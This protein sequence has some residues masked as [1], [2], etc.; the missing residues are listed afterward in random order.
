MF[1]RGA[2]A[3]AEQ[4]Q[5]DKEEAQTIINRFYK[6]F[7]TIKKWMEKEFKFT[8]TH[9]YVET[10]WGRRRYIPDA[11]M[12]KYSF[13]TNGIL[14]PKDFNPLD[15]E[16]ESNEEEWTTEIDENTKKYWSD[17]LTKNGHMRVRPKL[18]QGHKK[19]VSP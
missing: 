6:E 14:K 2:N 15:F 17:Q 19:K 11:L 9:G 10:Q 18:L 16:T 13:S 3:I 4:L 12:P 8:K 5:I 7:P 1:G